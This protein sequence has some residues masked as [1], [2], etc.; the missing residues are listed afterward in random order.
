MQIIFCKKAHSFD[1][2]LVHSNIRFYYNPFLLHIHYHRKLLNYIVLVHP[3]ALQP[4]H[5]NI[6]LYYNPFLLHIHYHSK[7]LDYIVRLHTL[8]LQPVHT[9]ILPYHS[10]G[11]L[12]IHFYSK[13]LDYIVLVHFPFLQVKKKCYKQLLHFSLSRF[14]QCYKLHKG[15]INHHFHLYGLINNQ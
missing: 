6:L 2:Q 11:L 7:L 5:T 3:L 1:L 8:A 9:N 14:P 15:I 13:L 10:L 12:H 4:V